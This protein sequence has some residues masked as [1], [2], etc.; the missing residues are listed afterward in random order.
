ML[1]TLISHFRKTDNGYPQSAPTYQKVPVIPGDFDSLITLYIYVASLELC[2]QQQ[3]V[4]PSVYKDLARNCRK[5]WDL[6]FC[7]GYGVFRVSVRSVYNKHLGLV[8]AETN[9]YHL[10]RFPTLYI[11]EGDTI[12][13][14]GI[15][16]SSRGNP[17]PSF[18]SQQ[19]I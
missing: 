17:K 13:I 15:T 2:Y 12:P 3:Y 18:I 4:P 8:S 6:A 9:L 19:E 5:G 11:S 14:P 10:L 16:T 7:H 1:P